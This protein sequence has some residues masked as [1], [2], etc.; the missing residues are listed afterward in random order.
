MQAEVMA[1]LIIDVDFGLALQ[2]LPLRLL[3]FAVLD[4]HQFNHAAD[5]IIS[6]TG[7][8]T[9]REFAAMI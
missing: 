5:F 6:G 3:R 2:A 7:W 4:R 1:F 8:D 9:L